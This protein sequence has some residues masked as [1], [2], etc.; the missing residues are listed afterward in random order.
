MTYVYFKE[1][2]VIVQKYDNNHFKSSYIK[3]IELIGEFKV[4]LNV[5]AT[6]NKSSPNQPSTSKFSDVEMQNSKDDLIL[7]SNDVKLKLRLILL[8]LWP[9]LRQISILLFFFSKND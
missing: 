2:W 1:S 5:V 7:S 8:Y 9:I 4:D 6:S 3:G